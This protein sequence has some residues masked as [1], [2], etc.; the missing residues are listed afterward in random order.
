M[1]EGAQI[2]QFAPS[3]FPA[4]RRDSVTSGEA[5]GSMALERQ[6]ST[7]DMSSIS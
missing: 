6:E 4:T 5:N 7:A 3:A 2:D 1:W